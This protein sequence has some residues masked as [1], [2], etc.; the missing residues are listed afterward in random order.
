MPNNKQVTYGRIVCD[1]TPDKQ[2]KHR[3]RLAVGGD[4]IFYNYDISTPTA[5]LITVKL[6]LNSVVSTPNAK[7]M[8]IDI[9][10]VYLNTEMTNFEY[11][12]MPISI[13]LQQIIDYYNLNNI[14]TNDDFVYMEIRKGMYGLPQAGK[15]A[16]EKL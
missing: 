2:E 11:M 6:L 10:N 4:R 7:F 1:I 3:T 13:F 12:K 5:E 15:L 14:V 16:H 8:T 9:K